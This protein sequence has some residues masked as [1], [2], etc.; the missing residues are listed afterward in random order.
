MI[1]QALQYLE[2]DGFSVMPVG[3]DKRPL[4]KE[5][6]F[7]Q[8]RKPTESE[9]RMWWKKFPNANIGIITGQISGIT[10]LDLDTYKDAETSASLS[11]FPATYTVRTGNG[12]SQLYYRYAAGFTISAGQFPRYPYVDLRSDGGYVVAPPSITFYKDKQG[13]EKGGEYQIINSCEFV[14]FPAHLFVEQKK[15]RSLS[16]KI[17][18]GEGSR[19]DSIASFIGTLLHSHKKEKWESD[20]WPAV[21]HAN[22]TYTPPLPDAELRATFNSILAKEEKKKRKAVVS[23]IQLPD[24]QQIHLKLRRNSNFV[25]YKD[26]ANVVIVF[27]THPDY[28][29]AFRYNEF[30]QEIEFNGRTLEDS[31]LM[32]I[33]HFLQSGTDLAG[34]SSEAIYAAIQHYAHL[35][36][37]DE[38]KDWLTSLIWDKTPRLSDWLS[39][40]LSIESDAYHAGI[41]AQWITGAVRRIMEPGSIFDHMLVLIGPQ[42]IGKTSFFRILGGKW[43]KSYTGAMDNKDFYLALRGA[44]IMDLDEGATLSRADSIKIKSIIS[45]TH[46]EYRPPYGRITKKHPRRFV[47]S[48]ST[49]DSEPFQDMTGN[50]R[51]WPVDFSEK[52]DFKWLEENRDQIFAEAY[53]YWKNKIEIPQVPADSA[54]KKQEEHMQEDSWNDLISNEVKKSLFYCM[55]DPGFFTTIGEVYGNAIGNDK[56]DRLNKGAQMRIAVIFKKSLGLE[57]KTE[58]I[59]TNV[60][61]VWRISLKKQKELQIKHQ[62]KTSD[63]YEDNF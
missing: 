1:T 16:S 55:G 31:H 57:R 60:R 43:Y 4:L 10:V 37:Y 8:D 3:K 12:G 59:D 61:K 29:K 52:V 40:T 36:S 54:M 63:P 19:N 42:G 41:G 58:Y 24:G 13:N 28:C 21:V 50:R 7:L 6:K 44:L 27:A 49:N 20:V 5:W 30:R 23:P 14:E 51:Y 2:M 26:M 35:F 39:R 18:V 33:Q 45:E 56:M 53:H 22:K 34:I 15:N 17:A 25:S 32:Q 38:A 62:Q 46:D 11:D 48:M 9:I 47:F